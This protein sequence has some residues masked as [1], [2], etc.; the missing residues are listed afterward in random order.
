[1]CRTRHQTEQ[2]EIDKIDDEC[3]RLEEEINVLNRE[4]AMQKHDIK[5]M[6]DG[7]AKE[8]EDSMVTLLTMLKESCWLRNNYLNDFFLFFFLFRQL[9]AEFKLQEAR[10]SQETIRAAIVQSPVR[11]KRE[12]ATAEDTL[13]SERSEV[14]DLERR[15]RSLEAEDDAVARAI[16][17]CRQY[18]QIHSLP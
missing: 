10:A 16:Q 13:R 3:L 2:P 8:I 4:Q 14:A 12:L 18:T 7:Q 6:K 17:V 11:L 5:T 1:V 15:Q 9:T